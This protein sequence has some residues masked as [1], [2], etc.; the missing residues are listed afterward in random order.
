M[1]EQDEFFEDSPR[2]IYRH[3]PLLSVIC[4]VRFPTILR[5]ESQVPSEFQDAIRSMFP[6]FE[7]T[8]MSGIPDDLPPEV[9]RMIGIAAQ[10]PVSY[11]FQTEDRLCTVSLEPGSLSLTS[12]NYRRWEE[13]TRFLNPPLEALIDTYKP[14]FFSRIG[15]RYQ[16]AIVPTEIGLAD[17][18]WADIISS[19]ILGE[20]RQQRFGR[21]EIREAH[22]LL[23]IVSDET[24]EGIFLQHGLGKVGP[25]QSNAYIIDIDCYSDQKAEVHDALPH[26]NRFNYRARRAFRWCV[27]DQLHS[28]LGPEGTSDVDIGGG[29]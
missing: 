22:R 27:S 10:Q 15:L 21:G 19:N 20:L 16:N 6:I 25:A 14:S 5:I 11:R 4:Q 2:V 1:L 13:F 23:R 7:R 12:T 8:Q 28:A 24:K 17:V 9:A 29:E 18:P 3:S 26:L